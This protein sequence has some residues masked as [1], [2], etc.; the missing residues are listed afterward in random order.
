MPVH[1]IACILRTCVLVS[2]LIT[3]TEDR[4]GATLA[5]HGVHAMLP[6]FCFK[7]RDDTRSAVQRG[8]IA[9]V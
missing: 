7:V 4:R 3:T 9:Q 8:K 1:E 2:F 6:R 5:E